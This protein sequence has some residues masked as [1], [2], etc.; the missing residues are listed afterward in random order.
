LIIGRIA[1]KVGH[2][3]RTSHDLLIRIPIRKTTKSPS[4]SAEHLP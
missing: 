3:P 4:R 2:Q 1:M